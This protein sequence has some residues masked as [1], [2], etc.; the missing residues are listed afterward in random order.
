[1]PCPRALCRVLVLCAPL[2]VVGV[3]G[4]SVEEMSRLAGKGSVRGVYEGVGDLAR[5]ND[6]ALARLRQ[7]LGNDVALQQGAQALARALTAGLRQG[8]LSPGDG[9]ALTGLA[10]ELVRR[11]VTAAVVALATDGGPAAT[12]ALREARPLIAALTRDAVLGLT[13]G[14]RLGTARDLDQATRLL[15][16]AAVS[17]ALSGVDR[18]LRGPLGPDLEHVLRGNVAPAVGEIT[19]TASREA[20]RGFREGVDQH[21]AHLIPFFN[22]S[23]SRLELALWIVSFAGGLLVLLLGTGCVLLFRSYRNSTR[24][25]AVVAGRINEH[26][27]PDLKKAIRDHATR[28]EVEPWLQRFLRDRGL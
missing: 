8:A 10:E 4:C 17:G 13:E 19:R 5:M 15:T 23:A 18:A 20:V 6:P 2:A 3:S 9:A 14:V 22:A 26:R 11:T 12:G 1:M 7:A 27:D 28:N 21:L 24:A 25:L 16:E